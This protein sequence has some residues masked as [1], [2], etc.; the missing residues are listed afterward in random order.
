MTKVN[1]DESSVDDGFLQKEEA[2]RT[3]FDAGFFA[4]KKLPPVQVLGFVVLALIDELATRYDDEELWN[5]LKFAAKSV[6]R[7]RTQRGS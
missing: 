5:S 2:V 7:G 4:S 6:V 3:L 1:E